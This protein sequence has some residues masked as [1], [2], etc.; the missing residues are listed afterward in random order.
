MQVEMSLAE[1]LINAIAYGKVPGVQFKRGWSDDRATFDGLKAVIGSRLDGARSVAVEEAL[2][3]LRDEHPHFKSAARL[4]VLEAECAQMSE[5]LGLP[6]TIRPAEGELRR[7]QQALG[8][9]ALLEDAAKSVLRDF[10]DEYEGRLYP[11]RVLVDPECVPSNGLEEK[12]K[13]G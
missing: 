7:M 10:G 9:V 1:M 3:K 12:E 8:R 6:P 11:L 5:E 13:H 4:K 2:H